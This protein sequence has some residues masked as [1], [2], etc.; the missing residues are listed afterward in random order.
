MPITPVLA[1]L[2]LE[3]QK[4]QVCLGS[5]V[6]EGKKWV[7][8]KSY[9]QVM[10]AEVVIWKDNY[11]VDQ[12][13]RTEGKG[14]TILLWKREGRKCSK[15]KS[16]LEPTTQRNK[17]F[18]SRE[19]QRRTSSDVKWEKETGKCCYCTSCKYSWCLSPQQWLENSWRTYQVQDWKDWMW[20]RTETSENWWGLTSSQG[21][22]SRVLLDLQRRLFGL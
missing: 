8:G 10:L 14:V 13:R 12:I 5:M 4:H 2:R 19:S 20:R 17:Q 11:F 22:N 9:L 7:L 3:V 6:R 15:T 16:W 21:P 1:W 18:C